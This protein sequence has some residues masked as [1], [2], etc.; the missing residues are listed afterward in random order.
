M[1]VLLWT[2][3][4]LLFWRLAVRAAFVG[5]AYGWREA[6]WSAPRVLSSNAVALLAARRA[7]FAYIGMLRGAAPRWDKTAHQFP[8]LAGKAR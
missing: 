6:L 5:S 3:L 1:Q 4:G 2:N 7:L 8:D